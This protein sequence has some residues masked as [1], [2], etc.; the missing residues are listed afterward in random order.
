MNTALK[1]IYRITLLLVSAW[2]LGACAGMSLSE[3]DSLALNMLEKDI[4]RL[5]HDID[6]RLTSSPESQI[7]ESLTVLDSILEFTAKVK[8]DPARFDA[9]Q[10]RLYQQK[11]DIINE[12]IARFSD[13]TLQADISFPSG[14]HTLERLSPHGR[15][16]SDHLVQRL[17]QT[18]HDL[19]VKYPQQRLRVTL[20]TIGYT[21]ETQIIQGSA[22]EQEIL[23]AL[24]QTPPT[25]PKARRMLFNEV[26]SH[27]RANTLSRY[28]H[29]ALY[30]T[31][32]AELQNKVEIHTRVIG[33]GETVPMAQH[34]Y[35]R[36][37]ERRRIC[38]VSPFVEVIP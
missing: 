30:A 3:H 17:Q 20:K 27:F 33:R 18:L 24:T 13:L 31:L 37:D 38:I 7:S 15:E 21:D 16:K 11:I 8:A 28:V 10:L 12:N 25:E 2:L 9:A 34:T 14:A 32:P 1:T 23:H 6:V 36:N 19:S 4:Q 5:R 29:S 22:L 26:L 35:E